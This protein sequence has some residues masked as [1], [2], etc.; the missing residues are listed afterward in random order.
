[1]G[2]SETPRLRKCLAEIH[3]MRNA[4]PAGKMMQQQYSK[5]K[6]IAS[7]VVELGEITE[8]NSILQCIKE[9]SGVKNVQKD[10]GD[11]LMI[12]V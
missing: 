5:S 12:M 2:I 8:C 9:M 11:D 7:N 3:Q 1:M 4:L 6:D 10:G